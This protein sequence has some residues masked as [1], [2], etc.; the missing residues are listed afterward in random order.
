MLASQIVKELIMPTPFL[1]K[2][3]KINDIEID[4]L[5]ILWEHAKKMTLK[6]TKR[7]VPKQAEYARITNLFK[8]MAKVKYPDLK[9]D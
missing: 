2:L 8:S 7:S 9:F 4:E 5:E 1:L 6:G 3:S